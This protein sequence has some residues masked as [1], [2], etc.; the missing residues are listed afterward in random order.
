MEPN[1]QAEKIVSVVIDHFNQIGYNVD[2]EKLKTNH[3]TDDTVIVR[4]TIVGLLFDSLNVKRKQQKIRVLLN[5]IAPNYVPRAI[6]R[7]NNR[8]ETCASFRRQYQA[9]EKKLGIEN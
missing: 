9:I 6:E 7:L 3:K 5:K 1:G 4:D 2:F 8:Y